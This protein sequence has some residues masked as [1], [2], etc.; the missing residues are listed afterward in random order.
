MLVMTA[1]SG[2]KDVRELAFA[3]TGLF[4]PGGMLGVLHWP[5]FRH[6]AVAAQ[7]GANRRLVQRVVPSA[8]GS[9]VF[10]ADIEVRAVPVGGPGAGE[11]VWPASGWDALKLGLSADG[12]ALVLSEEWLDADD[13]GITLVSTSPP[14]PVEWEVPTPRRF[15][16]DPL[17]HPSGEHFVTIESRWNEGVRVVTRAA[18]DGRELSATTVPLVAPRRAA[19]SPDGG[20]LVVAENRELY[21]TGVGTTPPP[22]VVV[23][24]NRRHFTAVAFHPSGKYLGAANNDGTV[25]LYDARTWAVARSFAWDVG[26]PA[27]L[28]FSPDG[29]LAAACTEKGKVVVWDV[30]V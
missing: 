17:F 6:G 10:A 14:F 3:P 21:V 9:R 5:E 11:V 25:K 18:A 28:A 13:L 7:L 1:P 26:R 27:A 16:C 8:D 20:T 15:L 22:R 2:T 19:L 4:A 30:D 12:S 29:A 23:N 24:A